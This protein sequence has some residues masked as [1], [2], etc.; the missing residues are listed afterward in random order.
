MAVLRQRRLMV[1]MT[2]K[3]VEY[4]SVA[5]IS[6]ILVIASVSRVT[7]TTLAVERAPELVR[8][9]RGGGVG[10]RSVLIAESGVCA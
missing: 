5:F 7:Y 3:Q 8:G 4:F 6:S 9:G 10:D 1:S 2:S